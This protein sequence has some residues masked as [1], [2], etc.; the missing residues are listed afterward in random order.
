[1]SVRFTVLQPGTISMKKT[2]HKPTILRR[3]TLSSVAAI[4]A[5]YSETTKPNN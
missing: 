3:E 2:Y 1:M 5:N 4:P